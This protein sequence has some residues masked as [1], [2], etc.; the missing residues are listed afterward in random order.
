MNYYIQLNNKG[1]TTAVY[2]L[3]KSNILTKIS[4]QGVSYP[5]LEQ[6]D[7]TKLSTTIESTFK[8]IKEKFLD[9]CTETSKCPKRF[10][11]NSKFHVII[12]GQIVFSGFSEKTREELSLFLLENAGNKIRV[13]DQQGITK[14]IMNSDLTEQASYSLSDI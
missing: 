14:A 2:S 8:T 9:G 12:E 11:P 4:A 6:V 1:V 7:W 13:V 5:L 3:N 10:K